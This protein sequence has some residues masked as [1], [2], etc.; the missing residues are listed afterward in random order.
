MRHNY[1]PNTQEAGALFKVM[2]GYL[3]KLPNESEVSLGYIIPH[4]KRKERKKLE[5]KRNNTAR[6]IDK[7][8]VDLKQ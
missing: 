2:L 3:V 1:S 8:T 5:R 4:L 6:A 7:V